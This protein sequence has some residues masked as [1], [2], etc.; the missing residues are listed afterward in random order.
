MKGFDVEK[1]FNPTVIM[2]CGFTISLIGFVFLK[3]KKLMIL[4]TVGTIV[5]ALGAIRLINVEYY[6]LAG[7]LACLHLC[8]PILYF[9]FQGRSNKADAQGPFRD[10]LQKEATVTK[11]LSP[12]GEIQIG[13]N[14]IPA[15]SE[16]LFVAQGDLVTVIRCGQ[17][18]VVVEKSK[19]V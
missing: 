1:W 16:G 8:I 4:F 18:R 2:L 19:K 6:R 14:I 11:E 7:I 9:G 15:T 12:K 10:Y 17:N 13:E 5:A 3:R